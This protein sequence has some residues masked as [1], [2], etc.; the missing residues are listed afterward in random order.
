MSVLIDTDVMIFMMR[1]H[2]RAIARLQAEAH[3]RISAVTY[4]ELAQGCRNK[5]ELA[6]IKK[7]LQMRGTDILPVE[8]AVSDLAMRLIDTYALSHAMQ[9]GDAL[10][11]ATA[12][13]HGLTVLT[14]NVKHFGAVAGLPLETFSP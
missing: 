12:L 7:G 8:K 6:N 10:I 2:L 11:A 13:E 14:A 5:L 4:M 3:W 9:M 1:G